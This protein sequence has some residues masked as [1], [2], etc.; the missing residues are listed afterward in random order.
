MALDEDMLK[1]A[2]MAYIKMGGQRKE[3]MILCASA[4]LRNPDSYEIV[5]NERSEYVRTGKFP[6]KEEETKFKE[7]IAVTSGIMRGTIEPVEADYYFTQAQVNKLQKEKALPETLE[8]TGRV[9]RYH[10][11]VNRGEMSVL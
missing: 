5:E 6:T 3:E 2:S 4:L 9:G 11:Y 7:A 10:T 8:K 1:V